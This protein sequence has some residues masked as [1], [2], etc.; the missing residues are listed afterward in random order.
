MK[1]PSEPN[2]TERTGLVRAALQEAA[3]YETE[4]VAPVNLVTNALARHN[5]SGRGCDQRR[6]TPVLVAATCGLFL[7]GGAL[8]LRMPHR[9]SLGEAVPNSAMA[10]LSRQ[11]SVLPDSL[12]LPRID[13]SPA[14]LAQIDLARLTASTERFRERSRNTHHSERHRRSGFLAQS[15]S[16]SNSSAPRSL[17]GHKSPAHCVWTTETVHSEIITQALTP[18]WVAQTDP[19]TATIVL[20]PALFQL[21]LQSDDDAADSTTALVAATL[22]PIR[23]EQEKEQP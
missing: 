10:F 11:K 7:L 19:V 4:T 2:E 12:A 5:R 15:P 17:S 22:I 13:L 18:V 8:W 9:L 21:A 16:G 14:F 20:T 23:F 6:P 1:F 3:R